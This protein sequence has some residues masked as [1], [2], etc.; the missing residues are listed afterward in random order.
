MPNRPAAIA[1]AAL[2]AIGLG[3]AGTAASAQAAR[4]NAAHTSSKAPGGV[5]APGNDTK[6]DGR[7]TLNGAGANSIDPFYERVFYDYHQANSKVTVNYSPAGSSVGVR[8]T[9]QGTVDFGDSEIPMSRADLVKAKGKILQVPVDLGGVAIS[10]NIPGLRG[11]LKLDGPTLAQI[12][13]G[14]IT[15]WDAPA[16]ARTTG[17]RNL[18]DLPIVAVHRADSSGPGW[19]VDS[20]LIATAPGWASKIGT[21]TASK[22]WP[23]SNVGVGQQLNSGVATYIK[24]TPGAIGYVEY[25][26]ALEAGFTNA[27]LKNQA[28]AYV[29]PSERSIAQA[30]AHAA[31][32]SWQHYSIINEPGA[33][34]YPLANFSWALL[35]QRRADQAKGIVLG[36]LLDY[37]VTTGQRE[38]AR[39][40]FAPLPENAVQVA[41]STLYKLENAAGKQLFAPPQAG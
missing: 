27:A 15:N 4:T 37:V 24:Q 22:T 25:G 17:I 38:A 1:A 7:I 23:L 3:L 10:Y 31:A 35:Y 19:D 40:G 20:Y 6:T 12:F 36:K 29:S 26:Y 11:G 14:T 18:P 28:G 5:L 41:R 13:E 2:V 30:G 33:S 34:T 9:E 32:L 21:T 8:D 16:I 39:L